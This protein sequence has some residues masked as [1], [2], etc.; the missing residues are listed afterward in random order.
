MPDR[1]E[2]PGLEPVFPDHCHEAASTQPDRLSPKSLYTSRTE[3][4]GQSTSRFENSLPEAINNPMVFF[5]Q[6]DHSGLQFM[7]TSPSEQPHTLVT[8]SDDSIPY[9]PKTR[10]SHTVDTG[11]INKMKL[12]RRHK[13]RYI[14]GGAGAI[15]CII[16]VAVLAGVFG[17]RATRHRSQSSSMGTISPNITSNSTT[18]TLSQIKQGSDLA[19][20]GWRTDN[21]IQIFLYYQDVNGTLRSSEYDSGRGSFTTNNS[22]WE[23]SQALVTV[24]ENTSVAAGIIIWYET[25]A[26]CDTPFFSRQAKILYSLFCSHK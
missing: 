13:R 24:A 26:V 9:T 11:N 18:V 22:Y 3:N 17:T 2:Q 12:S 20:T 10:S 7:Y 6:P 4:I 15:L 21:G 1:E 8:K 25:I 23:D 16:L 5:K 19:V 14:W